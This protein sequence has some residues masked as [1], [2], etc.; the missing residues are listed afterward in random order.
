[1]SLTRRS[2]NNVGKNEQ[3]LDHLQVYYHPDRFQY[4]MDLALD[5]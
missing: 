5:E 3:M 1:L 4:R 2:F